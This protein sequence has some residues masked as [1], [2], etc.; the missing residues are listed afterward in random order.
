MR[1]PTILTT[2]VAAVLVLA[3]PAASAWANAA[4]DRIL[5]DCQGSPNGVLRGTYPVQQLNHALH[6]I[7]GDQLEYSG[8]YDA[9]KQARLAAL[10]DDGND[11]GSGPAG[12][13]GGGGNGAVGGTGALGGAGGGSSAGG[14]DAV[15]EVP[16][17]PPPPG[18]DRPLDVAGSAVAP[19]SLPELGRD[20]HRLP[21]SLLALLALLGVAALVP[22]ALTIGRRVVGHRGD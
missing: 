5:A 4:D 17:A 9:I 21:T 12:T 10:H 15:S 13:G 19:G 18:A 1:P 14:T 6:N 8:C 3:L 7:P 20:A 22:A 11:G 16:S 2:L